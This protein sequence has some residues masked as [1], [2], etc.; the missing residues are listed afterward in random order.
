MENGLQTVDT[1]LRDFEYDS[2]LASSCSSDCWPAHMQEVSW[3]VWMWGS[4]RGPLQPTHIN[5]GINCFQCLKPRVYEA[6]L[7]ELVAL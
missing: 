7:T 1:I 4:R 5:Q 2:R 6:F 3:A